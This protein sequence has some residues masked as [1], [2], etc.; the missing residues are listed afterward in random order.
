VFPPWFSS[1]I[2]LP[3]RPSGARHALLDNAASDARATTAQGRWLIGV[4]IT[5]RVDHNRAPLYVGHSEVRHD[6][7]L[8]GVAAGIDGQ[9]GHI[10]LV[11]LAIR[12]EV[13]ASVG[14]VIM[15]TSRHAGRWLTIR[16]S[17]R[18]TIRIDVDM[19]STV[20]RR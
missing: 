5:A 1:V 9:H 17:A 19:E 12:P 15:A 20:A 4:I 16:S 18:T 3:E 8:R 14:W 7:G 2:M 6:H 13:F 10:A 11:A